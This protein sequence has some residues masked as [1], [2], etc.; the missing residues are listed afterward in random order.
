MVRNNEKLFTAE[1]R[2]R[3]ERHKDATVADVMVALDSIESKIEEKITEQLG[4]VNDKLNGVAD[5]EGEKAKVSE[6][7]A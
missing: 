2:N 7:M 1:R 5:E 6:I 4:K 3:R